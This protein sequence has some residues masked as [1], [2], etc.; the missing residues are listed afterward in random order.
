MTSAYLQAGGWLLIQAGAAG[1]A[2][3]GP[4]PPP[5]YHGWFEQVTVIANGLV[6][7]SFLILTC[8]LIPAA[9]SFRKGYHK[10]T[11]RLD[12]LQADI[13]PVLHQAKAIGEDVS[14]ITST[15]RADMGQVHTTLIAAN[16]RIQ[17]AVAITET[18]LNDFNALL[19]VVQEE[20]EELF[21][22]SV[23][24]VRGVK[25]GAAAFRRGDGPELASRG[26][27]DDT[28]GSPDPEDELDDDVEDTDGDDDLADGNSGE[29]GE[30]APAPPAPRLRPRPK[31]RRWS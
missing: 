8:L 3:V 28:A 7:I 13:H 16:D 31:Q 6:S 9:W 11:D 18:R 30:R 2:G 27:R 23:S 17:Q 25:M 12:Q 24:T 14:H 5:I 19:E 21:V 20:A 29:H 15:I 1:A 22:S 26:A 4:A 10:L